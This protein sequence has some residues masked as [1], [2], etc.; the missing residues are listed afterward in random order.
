MNNWK[1]RPAYI[2]YFKLLQ[3][4]ESRRLRVLSA[5]SQRRRGAFAEFGAVIGRHAAEMRKAEIERNIDHPLI[6]AGM[7]KPRVQLVQTD[8]PERT[9]DRDAEMTLE[10]QLQ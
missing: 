1:R 8:I 3:E 5:L 7:R 4:R 2:L 6:R 9:R 10:A